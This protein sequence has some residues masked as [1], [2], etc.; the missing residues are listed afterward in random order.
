MI[1]MN[2]KRQGNNATFRPK[3]L[4]SSVL[5][6]LKTSFM[7]KENITDIHHLRENS[8]STTAAGS[9]AS[10]PSD[11]STSA[12]TNYSTRPKRSSTSMASAWMQT[13]PRC[14]GSSLPKGPVTR[15]TESQGLAP[16]MGQQFDAKY[17]PIRWLGFF[18]DPKLNWKGHVKHWLNI[19]CAPSP[20]S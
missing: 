17:K 11:S 2:E 1:P 13:R 4:I 14:S 16:R 19:A 9:S 18:V 7:K 5:K 12:R 10:P 3:T 8:S 20:G 6:R 15:E